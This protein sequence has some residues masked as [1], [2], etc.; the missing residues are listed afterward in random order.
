MQGPCPY[1]P[2]QLAR[3]PRNY[4]Q[5]P[6][7]LTYEW[8]IDI[9]FI[10]QYNIYVHFLCSFDLVLWQLCKVLRHFRDHLLIQL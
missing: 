5:A 8:E 1:K 9:D 10:L 7:G 3:M 2:G 6:N 4:L